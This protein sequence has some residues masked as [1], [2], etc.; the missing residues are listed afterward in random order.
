MRPALETHVDG[1]IQGENK[2][3]IAHVAFSLRLNGLSN[4]QPN[5]Q[6]WSCVLLFLL[7]T[8]SKWKSESGMPALLKVSLAALVTVNT[9]IKNIKYSSVC[10]LTIQLLRSLFTI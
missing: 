1:E 2:K 8:T 10:V 3:I 7:K 4:T 6:P 5:T 9:D